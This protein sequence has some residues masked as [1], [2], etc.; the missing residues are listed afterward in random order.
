MTNTEWRTWSSS[1]SCTTFSTKLSSACSLSSRML[2][3]MIWGGVHR[4]GCW[5]RGAS[6]RQSFQE[7]GF[8]GDV[9]RRQRPSGAEVSPRSA[10]HATELLCGGWVC[11]KPPGAP[12]FLLRPAPPSSERKRCWP[13]LKG[14]LW[15]PHVSHSSGSCA[16]VTIASCPTQPPARCR[17]CHRGADPTPGPRSTYLFKIQV[18]LPRHVQGRE[19]VPNQPHEH[20]QVVGH[21][22]GDVEVSQCP[23]EHLVLCP[24]G[25]PSLQ[26]AGHHQHRLD[27]SQAPVIMILGRGGMDKRV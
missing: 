21:D 10:G 27:G 14:G 18:P 11:L 13:G 15:L 16:H 3:L 19:K 2:C 25:V 17:T 12:R 1:S 20:R 8:V 23:H 26:G 6:T 9:V 5:A 22:F 24:A 7:G 4:R